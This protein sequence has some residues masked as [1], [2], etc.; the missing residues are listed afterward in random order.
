M[1][2]QDIVFFI[3]FISLLIKRD[4]RL[5]AGI[6]IISLILSIPLFYFQIFFTAQGLTYYAAAFFLLPCIFYIINLRKQK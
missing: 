4:P 6:G 2:I 3:I 5:A 1:K